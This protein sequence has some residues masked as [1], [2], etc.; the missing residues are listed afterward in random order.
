MYNTGENM[1]DKD[2]DKDKE[3]IESCTYHTLGMYNGQMSGW[4]PNGLYR[5]SVY[6]HG[7]LLPSFL[8]ID[9]HIT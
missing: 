7:I 9:M 2:K 3:I 1:S 8:Y 6:I 5:D 4:S